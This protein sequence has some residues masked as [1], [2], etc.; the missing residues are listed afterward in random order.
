MATLRRMELS[1]SSDS[2]PEEQPTRTK[3]PRPSPG[4]VKVALTKNQKKA[5]K[6]H[7][8]KLVSKSTD[9]CWYASVDDSQVESQQLVRQPPRCVRRGRKTL[10]VY[11]GTGGLSDAMMCRGA[12]VQEVEIKRGGPGHD[13]TKKSVV[14]AY[15]KKAKQF[16]YAHMAIPCN[17]YSSSRYPKIRTKQFPAGLPATQLSEKEKDE[18]RMGNILRKNSLSMLRSLSDAKVPWTLENPMGSVLWS[19]KEWKKLEDDLKQEDKDQMHDIVLD[20]CRFKAPYKKR[21]RIALYTPDC[22]NFLKGL[23]KQCQCGRKKHITL[24]GWGDKGTK[25]MKT[26]DARE[27]PKALCSEWGRLVMKHLQ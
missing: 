13:F 4:K 25:K 3:R 20:C 19:T 24:S 18:I 26:S 1:D 17:Q 2:D 6:R 23:E 21:T 22:V 12:D 15:Q 8:H 7:A 9:F 10:E 16:G 5:N 27:Y 14:C 11:S